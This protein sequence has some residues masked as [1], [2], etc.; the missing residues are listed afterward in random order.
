M[1][2]QEEVV[3]EEAAAAEEDSWQLS[4]PGAVVRATGA[5]AQPSFKDIKE[6]NYHFLHGHV[7]KKR[8]FWD[9][10]YLNV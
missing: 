10:F 8:C 1:P 6:G 2:L 5:F 7:Q 9:F 4:Q 3:A